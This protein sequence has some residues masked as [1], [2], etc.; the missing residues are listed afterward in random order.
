M[1]KR[2]RVELDQED[3]DL[4]DEVARLQGVPTKVAMRSFLAEVRYALRRNVKVHLSVYWA[5][6]TD[7][8][9]GKARELQR[10]NDQALRKNSK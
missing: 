10:K 2:K 7:S 1:A 8:I 6:A 5:Q 4:L 9:L 3:S